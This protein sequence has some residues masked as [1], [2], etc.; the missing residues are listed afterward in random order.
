M[1]NKIKLHVIDTAALAFF[2]LNFRKC[3][4]EFIV[5][6]VIVGIIEMN[7]SFRRFRNFRFSFSLVVQNSLSVFDQFQATYETFRRKTETKNRKRFFLV[8]D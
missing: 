3:R 1:L 8:C 2:R 7:Q 6:V 5:V 4:L